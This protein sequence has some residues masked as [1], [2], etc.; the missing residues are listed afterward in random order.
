MRINTLKTLV[1]CFICSVFA[2]S[3]QNE[4]IELQKSVTVVVNPGDV[5]DS[6][7]PYNSEDLEMEND[8]DLGVAQLKMT[9]LV[10]DS[11]DNLYA[12]KETLVKDYNENASFD[13]LVEPDTD[14][15]FIAFSYSIYGPIEKPTYSPYVLSGEESLYNLKLKQTNVASYYSNYSVLGICDEIYYSQDEDNVELL[16][17][18][19]TVMVN[20]EW[21]NVNALHHQASSLFKYEQY[22]IVYHNNDTVSYKDGQFVY[23]TSLSTTQNNGR[24]LTT[25]LYPNSTDIYEVAN[26]LPGTFEIFGRG[27]FGNDN[28]DTP[29]KTISIKSGEQYVFTFNCSTFVI[30]ATKGQLKSTVKDADTVV[31]EGLY[32]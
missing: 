16:L 32:Q 9:L 1:L 2:V 22:Y 21:S 10:Y 7:I 11:E 25:S 6:F 29:H 15:K 26:F 18:P 31:G 4:P 3:C 12:K 19:A 17:R 20:L 27:W 8:E 28:R 30:S 24:S 23:S 5:L 14:Y 13:I